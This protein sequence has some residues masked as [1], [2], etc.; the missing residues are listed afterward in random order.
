LPFV[1]KTV[2]IRGK[3]KHRGKKRRVKTDQRT[4]ISEGFLGVCEACLPFGDL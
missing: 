2:L 1:D 3:K 4:I